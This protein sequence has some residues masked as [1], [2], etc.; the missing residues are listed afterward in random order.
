MPAKLY[1]SPEQLSALVEAVT[2]QRFALEKTE[3]GSERNCSLR[4]LE[5]GL[6]HLL[7]QGK[8]FA[9]VVVEE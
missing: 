4:P 3:S 8:K 9:L 2:Y 1:L 5:D 7:S 6:A